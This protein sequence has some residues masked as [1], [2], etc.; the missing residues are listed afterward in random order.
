MTASYEPFPQR[1]DGLNPDHS[2]V[3]A[4]GMTAHGCQRVTRV[5]ESNRTKSLGNNLGPG[6]RTR[7]SETV[8]FVFVFFCFSDFW[9]SISPYFFRIKIFSHAVSSGSMVQSGASLH[10]P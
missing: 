2:S 8:V 3:V 10:G 6:S 9:G 4:E 5:W 1:N 7:D